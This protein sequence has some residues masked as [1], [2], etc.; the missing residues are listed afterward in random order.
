MFVGE[1]YT[2]SQFHRILLEIVKKKNG[3]FSIAS[4]TELD[5]DAWAAARSHLLDISPQNKS[6]LLDIETAI[7]CATITDLHHKVGY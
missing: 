5:R 2:P 1:I 4:L 3:G 6:T 7:A